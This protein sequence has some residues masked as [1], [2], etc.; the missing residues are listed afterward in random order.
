[1]ITWGSDALNGAAP[2]SAQASLNMFSVTVH[3]RTI[4]KRLNWHCFSGGLPEE[5]LCW[6]KKHVWLMLTKLLLNKFLKQCPADGWAQNDPS[7]VLSPCLIYL[8]ICFEIGS[9]A[10]PC[11]A[12]V[13]NSGG[14]RVFWAHLENHSI[15]YSFTSLWNGADTGEF[16]VSNV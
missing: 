15:L 1:M 8:S 11:G 5:K 2:G 10:L 6:Q 12:S 13:M 7:L 9:I 4:R 16:L 14:G 3:D